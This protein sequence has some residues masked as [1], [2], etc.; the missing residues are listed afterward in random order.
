MRCSLQQPLY[1]IKLYTVPAGCVDLKIS[2]FTHNYF[3]MAEE[4]D[5]AETLSTIYFLMIFFVVRKN[6]NW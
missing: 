4:N 5:L 6:I 1:L 3:L 2:M